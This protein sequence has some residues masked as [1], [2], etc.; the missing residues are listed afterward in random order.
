MLLEV[1]V[2]AIPN[3]KLTTELN[4]QNCQIQLRQIGPALMCSLSVDDQVVFYNSICGNHARV[5]QFKSNLFSGALFF[6]DT[7]GDTDPY[8]DGL[9]TRY[10]LFYASEDDPLYAKVDSV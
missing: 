6:V 3:Q 7:L 9:G 2:M 4:A 1:P 8:Y 5:G 10:K